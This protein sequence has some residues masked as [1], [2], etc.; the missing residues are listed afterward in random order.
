MNIIKSLFLIFLFIGCKS[1]IPENLSG[2]W[3]MFHAYYKG[4]DVLG[5]DNTN[6]FMTSLFT[7]YEKGKFII[8]T[9]ESDIYGDIT[10]SKLNGKET[11]VISNSNDKRFNGKYDIELKIEREGRFENFFLKM[12][13]DEIEIIAEKNNTSF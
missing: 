11:L 9:E 8:D 5:N 1:K 2:K 12:I 3:N 7:I 4:K 10:H 13:S 6:L